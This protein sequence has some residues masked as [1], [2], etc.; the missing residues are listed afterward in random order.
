MTA[1]R[2]PTLH[3]LVVLLTAPVIAI[4]TDAASAPG[5][6]LALAGWAVTLTL[7]ASAAYRSVS[8]QWNELRRRN[9]SARGLALL[10]RSYV[11]LNLLVGIA[12]VGLLAGLGALFVAGLLMVRWF[13][14]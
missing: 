6:P 1:W 11:P 10:P 13:T 9:P 5:R 3:F 2:H 7:V 12:F 14:P 4:A 8:F